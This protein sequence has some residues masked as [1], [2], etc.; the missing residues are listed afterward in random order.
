MIGLESAPKADKILLKKKVAKN[1]KKSKFKKQKNQK[2]AP[3][4]KKKYLKI[5]ITDRFTAAIMR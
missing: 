3:K 2:K 5:S 4:A 1:I